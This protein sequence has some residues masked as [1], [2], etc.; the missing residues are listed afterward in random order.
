MFR[1][2]LPEDQLERAQRILEDC[3]VQIF[4]RLPMLNGFCVRH[5]LS[6][7]ELSLHT[8]PGLDRSQAVAEELGQVL[9]ALIEE[10]PDV[11]ERLRGRTFARS[12]Q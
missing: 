2:R 3:M 11:L 5:D 1:D 9:E 7:A 4:R 10:R 8:W 12:F 6:I